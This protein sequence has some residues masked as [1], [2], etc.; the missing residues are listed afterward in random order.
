MIFVDTCVLLD[1]V[2][3]PSDWS[4]WSDRRL[5]AWSLRGALVINDIVFAEF[6]A[7]YEALNAV[8]TAIEAMGVDVL[9][10]PHEA[11]FLA[12][13]AHRLYR[14]RGGHKA[15]VLPD[16]LIGAHAAV[17]C[18]PVMTRDPRRFTR[19]FSGLEIVS[20]AS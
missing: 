18:I 2:T 6:C 9:A 16:F 4:D 13:K 19:Y 17:L 1:V 8:E 5:A 11:L 12:S 14:R 15:S 3:P 7:G 10:I 20:P